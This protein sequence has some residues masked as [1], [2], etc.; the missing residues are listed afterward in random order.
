M[1]SCVKQGAFEVPQFS[2]FE[3]TGNAYISEIPI[4]MHGV[5]TRQDNSLRFV[6][7]LRQGILLGYGMIDTHTGEDSIVFSQ[8]SRSRKLLK[9]I[10]GALAEL[11]NLRDKG[12]T[13][14]YGWII[15]DNGDKML[16]KDQHLELTGKMR[17]S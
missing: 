16:Y 6:V 7:A 10:A 13:A 5:L 9:M 14:A 11:M 17:D 3:F 2:S 8:S 12:G 4:P 1:A 15:T